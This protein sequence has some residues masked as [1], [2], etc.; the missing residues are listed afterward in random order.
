MR[1]GMQLAVGDGFDVNA[2]RCADACRGFDAP[3][4]TTGHALVF[5]RRGA[6]VRRTAGREVNPPGPRRYGAAVRTR[7]LTHEGISGVWNSR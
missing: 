2:V 6:F 1:A 4:E 5:V 3:E 7:S